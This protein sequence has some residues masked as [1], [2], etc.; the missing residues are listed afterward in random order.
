M[1]PGREKKVFESDLVEKDFSHKRVG[2]EYEVK[3]T[4]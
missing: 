2:R 4:E 3:L 1:V